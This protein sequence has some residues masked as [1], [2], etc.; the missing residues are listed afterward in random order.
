MIALSCRE[1][2]MGKQSCLGPIDPQ[3]GGVPCQ[4]VLAE[5]ELAKQDIKNNPQSLG[6]WQV[7]IS[8]YHPTF[9]VS[10]RNAVKLSKDLAHKWIPISHPM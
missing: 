3:M 1:I 6:L 2:V 10:C 7:I 5:F 9:L 4:G 8:K